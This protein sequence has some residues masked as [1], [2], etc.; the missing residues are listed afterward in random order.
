MKSARDDFKQRHSQLQK[1]QMIIEAEV[2]EAV[3]RCQAFSH[4]QP[5]ASPSSSSTPAVASSSPKAAQ[6]LVSQQQPINVLDH[7]RWLCGLSHRM[8]AELESTRVSS[9]Q[10]AQ[11][12]QTLQQRV[13]EAGDVADKA[14]RAQEHEATWRAEK[15]AL[16]ARVRALQT[17]LDECWLGGDINSLPAASA[18]AFVDKVQ[19]KARVEIDGE[20]WCLVSMPASSSSSSAS[21]SSYQTQSSDPQHPAPVSSLAPA[22]SPALSPALS[23]ASSSAPAFPSSS[24]SCC[25]FWTP[26]HVL[27]RRLT[28][29]ADSA[30]ASNT[31]HARAASSSSSLCPITLPVPLHQEIERAVL[32]KSEA[33]LLGQKKHYEIA[34]SGK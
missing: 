4:L 16:E 23:P 11:Q 1:E 29:L 28:S 34:V 25:E 22:S 33:R 26:Q 15:T 12:V 18:D 24:S 8:A 5:S 2:T 14:K 9:Q 21:P 32:A 7:V 20:Q 6:P 27:I 3:E 19:V 17:D 31:A 13:N 30:R 10:L